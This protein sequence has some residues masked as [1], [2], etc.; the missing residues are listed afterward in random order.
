MAAI[1]PAPFLLSLDQETSGIIPPPGD[2]SRGFP[3]LPIPY[4]GV[5]NFEHENL[6]RESRLA[7]VRPSR[8]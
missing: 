7:G 3:S 4:R 2:K 1:D 5:N 6:T 8:R